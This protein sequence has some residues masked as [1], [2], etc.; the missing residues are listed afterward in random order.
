MFEPPARYIVIKIAPRQV[1]R[2][3]AGR[4]DG[5][6]R[7]LREAAAAVA[8]VQLVRSAIIAHER[9]QVAISVVVTPSDG[10][11]LA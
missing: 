2:G 3:A 10:V 7:D 1:S 11:G 4:R 8:L 9:V 6:A 5:G